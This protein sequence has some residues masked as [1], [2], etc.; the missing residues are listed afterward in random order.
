MMPHNGFFSAALFIAIASSF[1]P[2]GFLAAEDD[3]ASALSKEKIKTLE[4]RVRRFQPV[5]DRTGVRELFE[6]AL[7]AVDAN[8]RPDLVAK[9]F[10][11]A[12]EMQDRDPESRTYGNFRWYMFNPRPVDRNAVEFSMERASLVWILYR[13]RLNA[14]ALERLERLTEFSVEGIRGHKVPVSYTNIFLMKIWNCIALGEYTDRPALAQEGYDLLDQWLMDAWDAGIHEY[15]SPTYYGV[16]T[17]CLGLIARYAKREE[18]RKAAETALRLFWTDIAANW[19]E[20]AQRLGGAHSRDYDY[21]TGHG[22]LD[23]RLRASGWLTD[24]IPRKEDC[25]AKASAW[26]PPAELRELSLRAPRTVCQRWGDGWWERATQYVGKRFSIG[27]AGANYGPMDKTLVVNLPGGPEVPVVS[28]FMD[29]R[30]DPYGKNRIPQG[31]SGHEKALHL[32]PFL[33]GVQRGAE[34]LQVAAVDSES[35]VAFRHSPDPACL[36]SHVYFPLGVEVFTG[37]TGEAVSLEGKERVAVADGA[38]VFLRSEDVAVGIRCVVATRSGSD[39]PAPVFLSG[40]GA[41]YGAAR[42]TVEHSAGAPKGKAVVGL[43]VRAAEGLESGEAFDEFRRAFASAKAE[44]HR[45]GA[46]LELKAAGN[47]GPMRIVVDLEKEERLACEGGEPGLIEARLR[48]DAEDL[49]EKILENAGPI[50]KYRELVSAA[51]RGEKGAFAVERVIEAE[52]AHFIL[53]EFTVAEDAKASGGKFVWAPGEPGEGGGS[54]R[55]R[56]A[57]MVHVPRDGQWHLWAR[58]QAPTPSDD[59]FFVTVRQPGASE[60]QHLAWYTGTKPEWTWAPVQSGKGEDVEGF[61]VLDLKK[62]GALIEFSCREDGT[63]LDA[64]YLTSDP[65]GRPPE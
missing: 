42:F 21:L 2:G 7:D 50:R 30:G 24:G 9:A 41:K 58:V 57:W 48:V 51:E 49:G 14:E 6:F 36:L 63:R 15:G 4:A 1:W 10:E 52:A 35:K 5:R 46:Q 16:D 54:N 43:W 26:A 31:E 8:W 23:D 61:Q 65:D 12:E 44:S 29:G 47:A 28:F 3:A 11:I 55:A 59:S 18:E 27:S 62:G 53:T 38:P 60:D 39:E 32:M 13:D 19:Y 45:D 33:A 17:G 20:P 40:D 34:V 64:L 25:F 56:A 22:Y 37:E